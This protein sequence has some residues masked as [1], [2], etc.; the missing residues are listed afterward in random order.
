MSPHYETAAHTLLCLCQSGLTIPAGVDCRSV[1]LR[2][3]HM[4]DLRSVRHPDLSHAATASWIIDDLVRLKYVTIDAKR[5]VKLLAIVG[6]SI[7]N[8]DVQ[9]RRAF[10]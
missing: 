4:M 1:V 7:G 5:R 9:S 10:G 6:T 2:I 8:A 3:A